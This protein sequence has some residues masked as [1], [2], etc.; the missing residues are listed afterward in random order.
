MTFAMC[1]GLASCDDISDLN[2]DPNSPTSVPASNLLTQAEFSM[3]DLLAGRVYNAEWSML[4]V[5]QWAQTEYAED[6][7]YVV[8]ANSFNGTWTALYAGVLNELNV[9]RDRISN[10]ENLV[11]KIKQNQ[12]AVIEVLSIMAWQNIADAWGDVPYSQALNSVDFPN[13]SYDSQE[14]IYN[15][16]LQRLKSS[17]E[18]MDDSAPGFVS[19]D[20]L[21]NGNMSSWKKLASSLLMRMALRISDVDDGK[22]KEYAQAAN[23]IGM[24]AS[25]ADNVIFTFDAGMPD[26]SFPLY[27]DETLNNRDDFAVSDVLL[28]N[29]VSNNDPRLTAFADTIIGGTYRGMPYGL[30]DAEAFGLK[31]STSRPAK[32]VR[33]AGASYVVID[34]AE[35]SF[36]RAE[37]IQRGYIS[38]D[39]ASEYDAGIRSSMEFWGV[40]NG[41]EDY[42][43]ANGYDGSNWKESIGTQKWLAFY[44][45]GPQAWAEWRRLDFPK[46]DVPA[47]ASNPAIPVRL[48]Y[49]ISED[50]NNGINLDA[51]TSD[52]NDLNGKLWWDVN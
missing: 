36:M 24:L 35:V 19:G 12:L 21:L 6:S 50:Q 11:P 39:A 18:S 16:L 45:N 3:F 22:A 47:A 30:T 20:A 2:V 26:L 13:P 31:N 9:A 1:C 28:D 27:R 8:D 25:N 51:V 49:P 14:F 44:M 46:L 5:Q 32:A 42:I 34:F 37:A 48:P 43:S 33:A 23:S 15:D 10:D 7:R 38:G 52:I 4:M 41:V 40:S 29:L 17:I